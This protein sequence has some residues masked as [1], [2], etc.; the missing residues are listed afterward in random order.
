[1]K[2][3]FINMIAILLVLT[4]VSSC[5]ED[6]FELK[7]N[8]PVTISFS[9]VDS[10]NIVIVDKGVM[11]YSAQISVSATE[12]TIKFFEIYNADVKTGNRG[13]LINGTAQLLNAESEDGVTSFTFDYTIE[14]LS[15]NKCIK[16]VV[17]DVEGNTFERNLFVKITPAVL[18]TE[19]VKMETVENYYGPYFASWLNGRVYMRKDGETYKNEIDFSMGEVVIASVGTDTIPA[20]VDPSKRSDYKLLTIAGLQQ[21]RFELTSLT[22]AQYDAISKID[23]TPVASLPDPTQDAVEL[24]NNRVYLF[25]T[26]SG[27]KGLIHISALAAKTGTIENTA[28]EWIKNTPYHQISLSAKVVIN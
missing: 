8:A 23:A 1:M 3:L 17:T 27:K 7:Y 21:T 14:N 5:E 19:T 6:K 10:S 15:D 4:I 18:F 2:K 9:G 26:A 12:P 20:L 24:R 11:S 22:K 28:G 25:K 13:T 16:V